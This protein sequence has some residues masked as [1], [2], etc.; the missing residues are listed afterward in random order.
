MSTHDLVAFT[1]DWMKI[2]CSLARRYGELIRRQIAGKSA[3]HPMLIAYAIYRIF[4]DE[5][6]DRP[7]RIEPASNAFFSL[8]SPCHKLVSLWREFL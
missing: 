7:D 6:R 1:A 4:L 5:T 3:M 2:N 8:I